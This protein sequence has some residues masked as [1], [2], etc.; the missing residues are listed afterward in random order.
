MGTGEGNEY[1]RLSALLASIRLVFQSEI[2]EMINLS[3]QGKYAIPSQMLLDSTRD[4]LLEDIS[5]QPNLSPVTYAAKFFHKYRNDCPNT[6]NSASAKAIAF[7]VGNVYFQHDEQLASLR[8]YLFYFQGL[9]KCHQEQYDAIYLGQETTSRARAKQMKIATIPSYYSELKPAYLK[10]YG[11]LLY[12]GIDNV[13]KWVSPV[14]WNEIETNLKSKA[15]EF[16]KKH[17]AGIT[18]SMQR[19]DILSFGWLREVSTSA[20]KILDTTRLFYQSPYA[21]RAATDGRIVDAM[22]NRPQY[23]PHAYSNLNHIAHPFL[24]LESEPQ[25]HAYNAGLLAIRRD[26][27]S[28]RNRFI[29]G[30]LLL[31]ESLVRGSRAHKEFVEPGDEMMDF[32]ERHLTRR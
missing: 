27:I 6:G 32:T 23:G 2:Q 12:Q 17:R 13:K 18:D 29:P 21:I 19:D 3:N 9:A 31:V 30:D 7:L 15:L 1:A 16:D 20:S 8:V 28:G 25:M 22:M 10:D 26:A 5:L 4:E 11:N 24:N 14:Q